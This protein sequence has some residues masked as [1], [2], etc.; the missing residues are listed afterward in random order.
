MYRVL[1]PLD[2][3]GEQRERP[4]KHHSKQ[5]ASARG[6]EAL[7]RPAGWLCY[8]EPREPNTP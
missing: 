2:P 7:V 1:N 8:W 5:G 6:V 3:V 4:P